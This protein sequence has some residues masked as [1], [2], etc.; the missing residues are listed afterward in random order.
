VARRFANESLW[1]DFLAYHYTGRTFEPAT[2][3]IVVPDRSTSV[4]GPGAG[5]I[6]VS[7]IS[8]SDT[9]AAPGQPIL[10]S[11][12]IQG[13]N[14]G[15]I[16]L[17][18]GFFD[19][20]SNAIFVADSDYLESANTQ[21]LDGVYYPVWPEAQE[22]T[23]EFEWE[24]IVYAINDGENSVVAKF[25]PIPLRGPTPTPTAES[26]GTPDCTLTMES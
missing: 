3:T 4:I 25:L 19:Q 22:F 8:L 2:N 18:V 26:P 7:P 14:I 17:F 9:V 16:Y 1:D 23:M 24:P 21:E 11:T 6:E 12:D 15:Y 20:A 5:P 10:L 13:D